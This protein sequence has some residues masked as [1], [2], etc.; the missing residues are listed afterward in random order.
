MPLLWGLSDELEV[1]WLSEC[2]SKTF[3]EL[4]FSD[5]SLRGTTSANDSS[6][7]WRKLDFALAKALDGILQQSKESWTEDVVLKSRKLSQ[8]NIILKGRQIVWIMLDYFKTNRTLQEQYK[9]PISGIPEVDG[10]REVT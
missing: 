3:D 2:S 4:V 8:R 9:I 10:R 5:W 1:A 7:R 6:D